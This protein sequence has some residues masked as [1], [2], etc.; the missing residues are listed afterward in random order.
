MHLG[1]HAAT[2]PDRAAVVMA[3][4]G[5][6]LTFRQLDEESN[7]LGHVLRDGGL[8]PGDHIALLLENSPRFL[9]VLWAAQ[10]SGLVY[11]AIGTRAAAEEV[12]YILEDSGA[13]A[14]IAS[15]ATASTAVPAAAEGKASA[16]S[17]RL[18]AGGDAPGFDR[19][20]DVLAARP[21]TPVDDELEGVD[22]LYSSGTTGRPKGVE[23]APRRTA[24]GTPEGV[25]MLCRLLFGMDAATVY[26]SP[27]PLYH[28]A[29]LRFCRAVTRLGGTVVL[30]DRFDPV[31]ALAAIEA[32]RVTHSQWVPTMFIRMLR[33]PAEV[34]DRFDLSSLRY[35]IHGAAPCP[36]AV[37]ER[38]I[39]WWGP[40]VHEYYAGTEGNGF[41]YC[42]SEDW[43]AH[44]G[45]VGRALAGVLR[46]C[47]DDGE[48]LPT[49]RTGTVY[50][51]SG[52]PFEYHGDTERTAAARDPKGRGWTTLGDVGHLDEDRYLYLTDRKSY[53]VIS[54]GVNVYPQE[55]ENLLA[56]H[57]A[58]DDVAVF[59]V[60]DDDL[61]E[62]LHA[63]V[64]PVSME[65]AGPALAA[66]LVA[67]C[68][69]SLATFKCPRT[70]D[71]R[72]ELPREP[73]GKLYKRLLRDEYRAGA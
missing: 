7:R 12:A 61:G 28:A 23:P 31:A 32:N 19:Y 36:P 39:D 13:K 24:L 71:F 2:A 69:H 50:F 70:V 25:T 53:M 6:M 9:A 47:D 26:L 1:A 48:V 41:V 49:G 35:A 40:V 45:T 11:T 43:Q 57:P 59:G 33:L 66:E 44:P 63:V 4:T 29:P 42:N 5:E 30:M 34:R 65:A 14:F 16:L 64:Q 60:P 68:R 54:G 20:D 67:H 73:T 72:A 15:T 62:R 10:R 17:V 56:L 37:K 51:E 21:A 3:G 18:L 46:I 27:A 55:A 38:M 58:V 8:R 22:M 52:L